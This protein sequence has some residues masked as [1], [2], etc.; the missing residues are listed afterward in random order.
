MCLLEGGG[1][2]GGKK[3]LSLTV[4]GTIAGEQKTKSAP[5]RAA[6]QHYNGTLD[7]LVKIIRHEGWRGLYRGCGTGL[8]SPY[9]LAVLLLHT[10]WT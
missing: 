10:Q 9:S 7:A 3:S 4:R 2:I 1:D 6:H 5:Y 8:G